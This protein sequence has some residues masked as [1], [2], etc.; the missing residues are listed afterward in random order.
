[1]RHCDNAHEAF[2]K[3]VIESATQ[4]FNNYADETVIEDLNKRA[5]IEPAIFILSKV[6]A[7]DKFSE[8]LADLRS[9][10]VESKENEVYEGYKAFFFALGE[11]FKRGAADQ[12]AQ[13][14]KIIIAAL[15]QYDPDAVET[16]AFVSEAKVY[17]EHMGKGVSVDEAKARAIDVLKKKNIND[18]TDI[19]SVMYERRGGEVNVWNKEIFHDHIRKKAVLIDSEFS[20]F[21]S[22]ENE[23]KVWG[24]D[25]GI[26]ELIKD[27]FKLLKS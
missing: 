2:M 25:I 4:T 13:V 15:N 11:F 18:L 5:L 16:V 23:A 7:C 14:V 27:S 19:F 22:N 20:K 1:M 12:I 8:H 6:D 10:D 24:N 21:L 3:H 9:I 17:K 26:G